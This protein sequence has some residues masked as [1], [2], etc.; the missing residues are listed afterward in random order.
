MTKYGIEKKH[1]CFSL[2]P[3]SHVYERIADSYLPL[4]AGGSVYYCQN[5]LNFINEVQNCR[6]AMIMAVPRLYEKI[7]DQIMQAFQS[8]D[9]AVLA[10]KLRPLR[11]ST[12]FVCSTIQGH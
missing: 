9:K 6:P 11:C 8:E 3:L 7:F 1:L 5:I 4:F 12:I 2:L 10:I